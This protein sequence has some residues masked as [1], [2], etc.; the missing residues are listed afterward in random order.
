M[1]VSIHQRDGPLDTIR[2]K[3]RV[4]ADVCV[5]RGHSCLGNFL[6]LVSVMAQGPDLAARP[7]G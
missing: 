4:A 7:T 5:R 3:H 6:R 2:L 1:R